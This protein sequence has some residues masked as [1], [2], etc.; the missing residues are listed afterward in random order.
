MFTPSI[1]ASRTSAPAIMFIQ[2][3]STQVWVP[4]FLNQLPLADAMT[5]GCAAV[6]GTIAGARPNAARGAAAAR[7]AAVDVRTKSRRVIRRRMS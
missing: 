3:F 1:S 5:T 7:P 6:P 2:A 4:P